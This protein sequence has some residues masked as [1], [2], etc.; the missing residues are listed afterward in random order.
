M[1]DDIDK[2]QFLLVAAGIL[3]F[4]LLL[5]HIR[6]KTWISVKSEGN[7]LSPIAYMGY[8]KE[9]EAAEMRLTHDGLNKIVA[10]LLNEKEEDQP[11]VWLI[12]GE[13]DEEIN[14]FRL[15]GFIDE[16]GIIYKQRTKGEQPK[17]I[18][19][20][21]R[22]SAPNTPT[23]RGERTWESLWLD[24]KLDAFLGAPN[25]EDDPFK[26]RVAEARLSGICFRNTHCVSTE[27]KSCAAALFYKIYGP[28]KERHSIYKDP[29]YGWNDTALLTSIVYSILFLLLYFVYTCLLNRPL[30][31]EDLQA[32]GI[33]AGCYFGLWTIIRQIKINAIESGNSFQP[34]LDMLNKGIG[35]GKMD[36]AI[37]ALGG[38]CLYFS[39][40]YYDYDFIPL[41]MAIVFGVNKNKLIKNNQKPWTIITNYDEEKRT[42]DE[43]EK[44]KEFS[45]LNAPIGNV[46]KNY[47]WNLD[48]RMGK[49][50]QG[51]LTIQFNLDDL[52]VEREENPYFMQRKEKNKYDCICAMFK[53][54]VDN[55]KM[56]ER[57][58]Y[59][60]YYIQNESQIVHLDE[61]EKLQFVLDFVQEPNIAFV[62]SKDSKSI[63]YAVDY[64]RYPDE[65]LYDKEGD[66]NSKALLAA[67]LLYAMGYNVLFLS[68]EKYQ[69]SA[70]GIEIAPDSWLSH[71]YSEEETKKK[72]TIEFNH[73][74]YIFCET[75]N[76]GFQIG[77]IIE[78]M[79]IEDFETK[80]EIDA[81]IQ[82]N[83]EFENI[84][85]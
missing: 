68:S 24:S 43:D 38:L 72:T 76:N 7:N 31:G 81:Y 45:L 29:T 32:V 33:L 59:I 21:A 25:T 26:K 3:L 78:D 46:S 77:N 60:A 39:F 27:A 23:V 65:T 58:R 48:I 52:N 51:N 18:G 54:M 6:P 12:D 8:E 20:T 79:R 56:M 55:P 4:Y 5:Q 49:P 15:R 73:R 28:K 64:I 47:N 63:Q 80:I 17:A 62:L 42:D 53:K 16:K 22:P 36:H 10:R 85:S 69:H 11:E 70:V 1:F 71:Y 19:Y 75:T 50:V 13:N 41:I 34:Q 40:N 14:K 9:N 30:L 2:L 37:T 57:T 74:L 44:E 66:S 61:M 67:M 83:E 82:E 35:L 84:E